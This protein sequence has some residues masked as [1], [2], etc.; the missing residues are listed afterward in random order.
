[1]SYVEPSFMTSGAMFWI[2]AMCIYGVGCRRLGPGEIFL[3][4]DNLISPAGDPTMLIAG[5]TSRLCKGRFL[6]LLDWDL[7]RLERFSST[8]IMLGC[9]RVR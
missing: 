2:Y 6:N 8:Q 9:V 1:M 4:G 3:A 7:W 5:L